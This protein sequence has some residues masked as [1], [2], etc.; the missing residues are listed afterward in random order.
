MNNGIGLEPAG[1]TAR[2]EALSLG[3]AREEASCFYSRAFLLHVTHTTVCVGFPCPRRSPNGRPRVGKCWGE[4][5]KSD[6][7]G[8]LLG[9]Q[10]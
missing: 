1:A 2:L 4:Q 7:V 3:E 10:G 9:L 8:R 6:G 5:S